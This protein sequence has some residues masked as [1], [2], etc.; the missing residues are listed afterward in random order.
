MIAANVFLKMK[1]LK[2]VCGYTIVQN[3]ENIIDLDLTKK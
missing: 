3:I 2:I 1:N